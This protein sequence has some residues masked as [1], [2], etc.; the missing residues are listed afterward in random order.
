[1]LVWDPLLAFI[2]R[3]DWALSI[4][5]LSGNPKRDAVPEERRGLGPQRPDEEPQDD[6]RRDAFVLCGLAFRKA[7]RA[8][9]VARVAL[10]SSPPISCDKRHLR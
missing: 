7:G 2:R 10:E 6:L 1:M 4:R 3:N 9:R 8:S 5:F